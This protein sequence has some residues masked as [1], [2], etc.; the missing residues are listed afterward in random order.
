MQLDA[1][2]HSSIS[3][4]VGEPWHTSQINENLRIPR[5]TMSSHWRQMNNH[6][7]KAW[8]WSFV[9]MPR[10]ATLKVTGKCRRT[11]RQATCART[12]GKRRH[13]QVHVLYMILYGHNKLSVSSKI[14]TES[15]YEFRSIFRKDRLA[16]NISWKVESLRNQKHETRKDA[17]REMIESRSINAYPT[18]GSN[19]NFVKHL[20]ISK[21]E[22]FSISRCFNRSILELDNLQEVCSIVCM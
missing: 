20:D 5:K 8:K 21:A 19:W 2:T 9:S 15:I 22:D 4:S 3:S 13:T 17:H 18:S 11:T 10:H 14:T 12:H 7:E 16:E 1:L 6:H